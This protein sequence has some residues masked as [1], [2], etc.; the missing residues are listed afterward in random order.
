[1]V[2]LQGANGLSDNGIKVGQKIKIPD[3]K[4]SSKTAV[5]GTNVNSDSAAQAPVAKTQTPAAT[6]Q[7][8]PASSASAALSS[9]SDMSLKSWK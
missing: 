5:S 6:S 1:M 4:E 3:G 7:Q 9:S 2:E 8:S